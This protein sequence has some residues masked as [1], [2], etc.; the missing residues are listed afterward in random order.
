MYY[1]L[2]STFPYTYAVAVL[3]CI[4]TYEW[5]LLQKSDI[6][7]TQL[8]GLNMDSSLH[9]NSLETY[10]MSCTFGLLFKFSPKT[11]KKFATFVF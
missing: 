10:A 4:F 11:G 6:L 8:F 7:P 9:E 5:Y 1:V 2:R 3:L